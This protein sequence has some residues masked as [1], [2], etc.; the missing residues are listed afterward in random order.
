MCGRREARASDWLLGHLLT[1]GGTCDQQAAIVL[2]N[3]GG[4]EACLPSS[5]VSP[6]ALIP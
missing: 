6:E 1:E 4:E 3:D 5:E 2:R